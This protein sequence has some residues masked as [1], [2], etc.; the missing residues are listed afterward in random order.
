M[1]SRTLRRR[2]NQFSHRHGKPVPPLGYGLDHLDAVFPIS[3]DLSQVGD[4]LCQGG[5]LD[6]DPWPKAADEIVLVDEPAFALEQER[7]ASQKPSAS[8]QQAFLRGAGSARSGL[9]GSPRT[10]ISAS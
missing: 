9:P 8:A 5:I 4:V 3:Q 1:S 7:A 10:H 6:K 2:V